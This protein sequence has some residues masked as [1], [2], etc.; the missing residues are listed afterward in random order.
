MKRTQ[1]LACVQVSSIIR[2][3]P[4]ALLVSCP[5]PNP[6]WSSRITSS[7]FLSV[8]HLSILSTVLAVCARRLIV[9]WW[10]HFVTCGFLFKAF[11]IISM[12]SLGH[13]QTSNMSSISCVSILRSSSPNILVTFTGTLSSPVGFLSNISLKFETNN[14]EIWTPLCTCT[15]WC[16]WNQLGMMRRSVSKRDF[17]KSLVPMQDVG[18][19]KFV[20]IPNERLR[21]L[22][23]WASFRTVISRGWLD[24]AWMKWD[25]P[26]I[27]KNI[28]WKAYW[29]STTRI[30][31]PAGGI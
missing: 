8:L 21:N 27:H 12:K 31:G 26:K 25:K 24:D 13:S 1:F 19:E 7:I 16:P 29:E 28:W 10:L 17:H 5:V 11:V 20:I 30:T 23:S 9:W 22:Q 3:T 15:Q 18:S 2:S 14:W 4:V 6:N